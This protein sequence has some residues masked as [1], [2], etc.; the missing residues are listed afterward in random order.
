MK[1]LL[2]I[3]LAAGFAALLA[4][5]ATAAVIGSVSFAIS[6]ATLIAADY[7]RSYSKLLTE[8]ATP[9]RTRES[10]RLAA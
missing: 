3:T 10:L 8:P 2:P 6:M 1:T 9:S 4:L 5:P 7:G